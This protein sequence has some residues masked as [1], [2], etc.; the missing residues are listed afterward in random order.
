[1]GRTV[2]IQGKLDDA[3]TWALQVEL[4]S[5]IGAN[6]LPATQIE[7]GAIGQELRLRGRVRICLESVEVNRHVNA[8][9]WR[10]YGR[11]SE[12]TV[13]RDHGE[14]ELVCPGAKGLIA[15]AHGELSNL[16]RGWRR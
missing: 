6:G 8:T 14:L 16:Q 13:V 12:A 4:R 9:E 2:A 5:I 1:M 10:R 11:W 3:G 7:F 15:D